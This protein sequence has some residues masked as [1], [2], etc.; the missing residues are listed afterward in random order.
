MLGEV[1]SAIGRAFAPID[2]ELALAN[3]IANPIEAHVDDFGPLLL[4]GV[5]GDTA[6]SVIVGGHGSG[7]LWMAH[8]FEG[9][10]EGTCFLA[11]MEQGAE[12]GFGSAGQ[13]FTHDVA[14]NMDGAVGLVGAV[15]LGGLAGQEK[16][17]GS[18][19]ASFDDGEIRGVAFNG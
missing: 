2:L 12:F 19:R 6:G 13:D 11:I 15:G 14:E 5:G 17:A 9:N 18:A 7:R 10:A 8:F 1:I 4:D 3:A 16:V